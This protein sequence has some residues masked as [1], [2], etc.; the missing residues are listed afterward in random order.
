MEQNKR[1]RGDAEAWGEV[2]GRFAG[3]GLS[4]PAFCVH[5]GISEASFYRWRSMLQAGDAGGRKP[6]RAAAI[7]AGVTN[8]PTPFVDLG[9]LQPGGARVE[10]RLDLGGGVLV[11]LVRG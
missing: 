3:S 10:L 7:V 11:H 8:R 2:L 6:R 1:R 4:V 5:E 9:T